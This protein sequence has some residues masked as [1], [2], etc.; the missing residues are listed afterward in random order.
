MSRLE[1][2]SYR[3]ETG[4][5]TPLVFIHGWLGSKNSW[6]GVKKEIDVDNPEVFYDQRCHGDSTCSSFDF[7]TLAE[8]LNALIEEL[9]L[10]DPL[11]VGHSMGGMVALTYATEYDDFSGLFL[12]G[13]CAST[14]EPENHS[15]RFFLEKFGSM[16]RRAWAME[17]VENYAAETEDEEAKDMARRELIDA[18]DTEV[19]YSLGSMIGYDLEDD[20]EEINEPAA[21]VAGEKD[22]AITMEKSEE[23]SEL[24]DCPLHEIETSHL[25]LQENP[26]KIAELLSDFVSEKLD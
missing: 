2:I 24:L 17:I 1:G 25:M 12:L 10:E 13:S 8:D 5:G 15:P 4:E 6:D 3:T 11:L 9:G 21:V 7:E 14:P 22:G 19:I 23:L 18:G 16:D 20:I 26:G